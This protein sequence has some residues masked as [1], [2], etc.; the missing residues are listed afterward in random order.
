MEQVVAAEPE[1]PPLLVAVGSLTA[2]IAS[3]GY[4]AGMTT[5]VPPLAPPT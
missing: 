2:R 4:D 1:Q 3:P 5:T